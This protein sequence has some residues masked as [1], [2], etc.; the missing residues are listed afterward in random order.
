MDTLN[1]LQ[2]VLDP[3]QKVNPLLKT[4]G[5]R[6]VELNP[7]RAVM[8]LE[9]TP[10]LLQ[11]AGNLAGGILGTLADEAMAHVLMASLNGSRPIVTIEMNIRFLRPAKKGSISCTAVILRQ[12]RSTAALEAHIHGCEGELLAVAGA[13]FH[14]K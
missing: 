3:E 7:Q 6:I 1:Y 14:I 5:V 12:G 2:Q 9:I 8:T 13:T 11:G 4:L 10:G